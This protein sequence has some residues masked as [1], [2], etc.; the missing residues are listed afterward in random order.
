MK[1]DKVADSGNDE[2]YTPM[3][4]VEPL[5]KYISVDSPIWCPFDTSDSLIVKFFKDRGNSV[6]NTHLSGGTDFFN[7]EFPKSRIVVSNPPYSR[8]GDVLQRLF[9]QKVRFAMLV[10]VVGLFESEKRFSMFQ[11]NKF[12]VM[13]MNKR[14]SYFKSYTDQKPSINPPFSSVWLTSG[15]LPNGNVFERIKK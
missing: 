11:G 12:E 14:I 9:D 3:Y 7:I 6:V 2:F 8:K 5:G 15:I 10:G 4:A 13:W 1:M